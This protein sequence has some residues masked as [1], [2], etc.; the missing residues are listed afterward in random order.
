MSDTAAATKD[1][2]G[3]NLPMIRLISVVEQAVLNPDIDIAKMERLLELQERVMARQSEMDFDNA[4]AAAQSEMDAIRVDLR[5]PETRKRYASLYALDQAVR[6]IY[7]KHGF[8]LSFNTEPTEKTDDIRVVCYCTCAGH[9][10]VYQLDLPADGKGPKGGAVMTRTHATGAA[11]SYGQ[12]YLTKMIF[13]LAV[14]HDDDGNSAGAQRQQTQQRQQ[15]AKTEP[16]QQA[17]EQPKE[18]T[19]AKPAD[20]TPISDEQCKAL[21]KTVNE[22]TELAQGD[23]GVFDPGKIYKHFKIEKMTQLPASK[24]GT[25]AQQLEKKRGEIKEAIRREAGNE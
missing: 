25:V 3:A 2:P 10:R 12:R 23:L 1:A 14:E 11:C 9:R 21:I 22:L 5:N 7:T 18:K 4:M 8:S 13:N 19:E 6:P 20:D 17:K 24:F 16:K 15:P